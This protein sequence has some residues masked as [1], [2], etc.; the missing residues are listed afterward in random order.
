M[1][2]MNNIIFIFFPFPSY[3]IYHARTAG[4][5]GFHDVAVLAFNFIECS[6]A[7]SE[8][9][10]AKE[11]KYSYAFFIPHWITLWKKG[12]CLL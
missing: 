6:L 1:Y 4:L 7:D 11:R 2:P 5:L 9:K 10:A 8:H 12:M 3:S